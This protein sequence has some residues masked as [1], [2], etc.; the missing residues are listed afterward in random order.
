MTELVYEKA[1]RK[2]LRVEFPDGTIFCFKNAT[3]TFIEAIKKIGPDVFA[4]AGLEIGHLPMV[5]TECYE[6]Y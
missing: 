1:K 2:R 6:R 5:S 4:S 3:T